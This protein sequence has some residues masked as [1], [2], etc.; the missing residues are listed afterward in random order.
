MKGRDGLSQEYVGLFRG[1]ANSLVNKSPITKMRWL[2]NIWAGRD[3]LHTEEGLE[4][5]MRDP[6]ASLFIKRNQVRRKRQRGIG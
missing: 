1:T 5:V 2:S 3:R 4:P 6:L